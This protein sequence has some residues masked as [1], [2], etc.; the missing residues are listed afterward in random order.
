MLTKKEQ[1]IFN[2]FLKIWRNRTFKGGEI[3]VIFHNYEPQGIVY[4]QEKFFTT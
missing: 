3:I 1:R 4:K 2:I